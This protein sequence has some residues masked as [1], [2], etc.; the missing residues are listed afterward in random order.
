[1]A[2]VMG[3]SLTIVRGS[4]TEIVL[5][6][7][8]ANFSESPTGWSLQLS[9][10]K[11]RGQTPVLTVTAISITGGGPY[12]ATIPLTR[13]QTA[14]LTWDEYDFDLFRT[15]VGSVSPKA[16]GKLTVQTPVYPVPA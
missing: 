15:D 4:D 8:T 13:A 2:D 1:M 6:G 10:A 3:Q 11:N 9:I 12:V 16:G 14:L 5:T 7:A